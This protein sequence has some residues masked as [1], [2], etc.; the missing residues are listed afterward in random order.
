MA[1]LYKN[2]MTKDADLTKMV[3]TDDMSKAFEEQLVR[4][5]KLDEL[6]KRMP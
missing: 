6:R 5:R 4:A 1:T 2:G 3:F